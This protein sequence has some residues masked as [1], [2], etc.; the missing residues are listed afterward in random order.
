MKTIVK[1]FILLIHS[2]QLS[3]QVI[4]LGIINDPDGYTNVRSGKGIE[5]NV[6][7]KI[8]EGE[9][10]S[11]ESNNENWWPVITKSG[12][13]GYVHKSRVA[14]LRNFEKYNARINDPDGYTNIR[15]GKGTSFT[16]LD[17]IFE[18]E[19][20]IV[21]KNEFSNWWIVRKNNG[22]TGYMH[23]SRIQIVSPY[24]FSHDGHINRENIEPS[25]KYK[26]Y[27]QLP[28]FP[29]SISIGS[30]GLEAGWDV[31]LSYRSKRLGT[32]GVSAEYKYN[33]ARPFSLNGNQVNNNDLLVILR[34]S[35]A[36]KD[37]VY[38][39]ADGLGFGI[40][41]DGRTAITV[42]NGQVIIDVTN[43]NI[44]DLTLTK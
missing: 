40:I 6:L 39:I 20:F 17:K 41:V 33:S 43:G 37:E 8:Y 14:I 13:R 15:S 22:V 29:F 3:A 7:T 42:K 34:N 10:F 21:E 25:L 28:F 27:W 4:E 26:L 5:Y 1:V 23:K 30:E 24:F 31:D 2:S 44:K 19:N 12:V 36:Q 38:K 35:N 18:G 32:F 9:V 11:V 16:I